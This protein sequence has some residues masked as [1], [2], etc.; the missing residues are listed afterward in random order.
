MKQ[1]ALV[2]VSIVKDPSPLPMRVIHRISSRQLGRKGA[3]ISRLR[4]KL[5]L[6]LGT[7]GAGATKLSS[8]HP[9]ER[10]CGTTRPASQAAFVLAALFLQ[11]KIE[12]YDRPSFGMWMTD[13]IRRISVWQKSVSG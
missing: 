1:G 6:Y 12:M 11:K 3:L 4:L 9:P 7:F 10:P 5:E 2:A 8:I 13:R